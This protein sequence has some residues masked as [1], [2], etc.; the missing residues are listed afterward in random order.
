VSNTGVIFKRGGC[1][2]SARRRL[3][4]SC[5]RLAERGH[6]TWYFHSSATNLLGRRE[7][8]RR[9]GFPSQAAARRA[10]DEWLAGAEVDVFHLVHDRGGC[11]DDGVDDWGDVGLV[12]GFEGADDVVL[13]EVVSGVVDRCDHGDRRV[14]HCLDVADRVPPG[15]VPAGVGTD[16]RVVADVG[17]RVGATGNHRVR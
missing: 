11:V 3:E 12:G 2:D 14:Y 15:A 16:Y 5:P 1:R 17:E 4:N 10:R 13:D 6:G 8:V 9:G 7:R